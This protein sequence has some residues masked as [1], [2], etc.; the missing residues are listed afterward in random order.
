MLAVNV[1]LPIRKENIMMDKVMWYVQ[2]PV[3]RPIFLNSMS[4][5]IYMYIYVYI[6]IYICIYI[7]IYMYIYIYIY[8]I[9]IYIYI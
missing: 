7:Y 4:N 1:C 3:S 5:V 2:Q 6:Y 8:I 9:Y